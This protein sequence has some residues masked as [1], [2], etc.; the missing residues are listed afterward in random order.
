MVDYEKGT[1]SW[2]IG[3]IITRHDVDCAKRVILRS[4]TVRP[5]GER[6]DE[7]NHMACTCGR[8]E[9]PAE[10]TRRRANGPRRVGV[11]S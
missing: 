11:G 3:I 5:A 10:T 7:A 1:P 6:A 4:N 9:S 2:D 8:G